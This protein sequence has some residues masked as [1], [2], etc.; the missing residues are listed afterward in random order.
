M[1]DDKVDAGP[2]LDEQVS[3]IRQSYWLAL[4]RLADM[5]RED[6]LFSDEADQTT[7]LEASAFI[8][9]ILADDSVAA[10]HL[11]LG[12][13]IWTLEE[14]EYQLGRDARHLLTMAK[15]T[16][17]A[18]ILRTQPTPEQDSA[19]RHSQQRSHEPHQTS[20]AKHRQSPDTSQQKATHMTNA[21]RQAPG[22]RRNSKVG[23]SQLRWTQA[24]TI[25]RRRNRRRHAAQQQGNTDI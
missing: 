16:K 2:G 13:L 7:S 22:S 1:P 21:N 23:Q 15:Q 10:A 11:Q 9:F 6:G 24:P 18:R 17:P 12:R 20:L 4:S 3:R 25:Q 5:Q 14:V 19:H 8:C